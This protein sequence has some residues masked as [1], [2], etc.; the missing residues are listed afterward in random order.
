MLI[1]NKSETVAPAGPGPADVGNVG[2]DA[3]FHAGEQTM[4]QGGSNEDETSSP[5]MSPMDSSTIVLSLVVELSPGV[6]I[7]RATEGQ[8]WLRVPF[9]INGFL[10]LSLRSLH[11]RWSST[12]SGSGA[13]PPTRRVTATAS[14]ILGCGCRRAW[15]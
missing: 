9:G 13:S 3:Q 14:A 15:R 10:A 4:G 5:G 7:N 2:A 12:T 8:V 6:F 1:I 11:V